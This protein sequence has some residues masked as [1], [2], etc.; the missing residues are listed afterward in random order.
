M[1]VESILYSPNFLRGKDSGKGRILPQPLSILGFRAQEFANLIHRSAQDPLPFRIASQERRRAGILPRPA[2]K[3]PASYIQQRRTF[4]QPARHAPG[5][6]EADG[7]LKFVRHERHSN[8]SVQFVPAFEYR[9]FRRT[10]NQLLTNIQHGQISL[11]KMFNSM[12]PGIMNMSFETRPIDV[13]R[14]RRSPAIFRARSLPA[15]NRN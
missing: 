15:P 8:S 13:A 11:A 5:E 10:P 9:R 7:I 4:A 1:A 2:L 14:I 12:H 3:V 6:F